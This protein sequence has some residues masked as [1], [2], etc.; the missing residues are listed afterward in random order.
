MPETEGQISGAENIQSLQET[1]A[2][3]GNRFQVVLK[4]IFV[5]AVIIVLIGYFVLNRTSIF[6]PPKQTDQSSRLKKDETSITINEKPQ[7][8][9]FMDIKNQLI[10]AFK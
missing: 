5:A 1:I 7:A 3:P 9:M 2:V 4:I 8:E 10:K 6:S